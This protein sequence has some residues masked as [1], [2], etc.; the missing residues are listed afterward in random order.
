M[1]TF[2]KLGWLLS[3]VLLCCHTSLYAQYVLFGKVTDAEHLALNKAGIALEQDSTLVSF[4]LTDEKGK[5]T[6]KDLPKEIMK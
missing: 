6:F 3:G 5:Y 4:T 1:Q 2:Y